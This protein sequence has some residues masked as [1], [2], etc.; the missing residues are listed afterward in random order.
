M[1]TGCR[2]NGILTTLLR[3]EP[4]TGIPGCSVQRLAPSSNWRLLG[5]KRRHV[6]TIIMFVC[7]FLFF[8]FLCEP[9]KC[10]LNYYF[11]FTDGDGCFHF[12]DMLSDDVLVPAEGWQRIEHVSMNLL[13]VRK[14]VKCKMIWMEIGTLRRQNGGTLKRGAVGKAWIASLR[15]LEKLRIGWNETLLPFGL[16]RFKAFSASAIPCHFFP[17]GQ[18]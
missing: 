16:F 17:V 10:K 12:V 14:I 4:S 15:I 8:F 7:F 5:L 3:I 11:A 1:I 2:G 9:F 6:Q 13:V 18:K